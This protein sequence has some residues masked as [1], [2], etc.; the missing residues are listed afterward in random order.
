MEITK[1]VYSLH[2]RETSRQGNKGTVPS[3][4]NRCMLFVLIQGSSCLETGSYLLNYAGC[5]NCNAKGFMKESEKVSE[6]ENDG[7]VERISYKR[8]CTVR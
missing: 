8:E 1:Y 2:Q 7:S 5:S 6:V 4:I 3:V